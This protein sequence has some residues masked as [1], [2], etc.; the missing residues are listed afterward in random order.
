MKMV[1][2]HNRRAEDELEPGTN[3]RTS[4]G[5]NDNNSKNRL[6]ETGDAQLVDTDLDGTSVP[7]DVA[8]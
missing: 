7:R 3:G 4:S 6:N 1:R 2:L 5:I 8:R